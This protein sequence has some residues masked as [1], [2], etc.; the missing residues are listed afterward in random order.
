M[1]SS[2]TS[3]SFSSL[4]STSRPN[5]AAPTPAPSAPPKEGFAADAEKD[6]ASSSSLCFFASACLSLH[7]NFF[8]PPL[9]VLG[10][11]DGAD[12]DAAICSCHR[13]P[14]LPGFASW[15]GVYEVPTGSGREG[16]DSDA[17]TTSGA[18]LG[19][20]VGTGGEGAAGF[21]R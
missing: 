4:L 20:G 21:G 10:E 3:G 13:F 18:L 11:D 7:V 15:T 2:S 14:S 9:T 1:L 6:L 17:R 16:M 5:A 19:A 12:C 8:S